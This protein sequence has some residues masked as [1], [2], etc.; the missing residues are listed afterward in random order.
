MPTMLIHGEPGR[1]T[2]YEIDPAV[3]LAPDQ[4]GLGMPLVPMT[5]GSDF[6][7]FVTL[8]EELRTY[9]LALTPPALTLRLEFVSFA[10]DAGPEIHVHAEAFNE[11]MPVPSIVGT[12]DLPVVPCPLVTGPGHLGTFIGHID[13]DLTAFLSTVL[14]TT[15]LV[16]TLNRRA[17]G[18]PSTPIWFA[19][20]HCLQE[21]QV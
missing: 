18:G 14:P 3:E 1:Y 12:V 17:E 21:V 11:T 2:W 15:H 6:S 9:C 4:Y 13:V 19:L 10:I 8:N 5:P 20:S 16:V 7:L